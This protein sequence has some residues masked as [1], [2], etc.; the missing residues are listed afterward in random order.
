MSG[1]SVG[2]IVI[3]RNEGERLRICLRSA[4]D[5]A[6]R[7]Y[8]DSGSTDGSQ[9][10]ATTLGFHVVSLDPNVGFT[11]ARARNAGLTFLS[12]RFRDLQFVQT[13][14]G[15][16]EIDPHWLRSA[17]RDLQE[18]P[19]IAVV[20]GRRRERDPDRNIYHKACDIEWRAPVGE[21]SSCGGDALFRTAALLEV[22]GFNP[23]LI[24]GEEPDLCLRLR[25]RGWRVISNGR[26]MTLHDVSIASF[27]QWWR[28]ALRAGYG[29]SELV[30]IHGS[31]SDPSWKRFLISTA[32]WTSLALSSLFVLAIAPWPLSLA[33]PAFVAVL[34]ALQICRTGFRFRDRFSRTTD[35]LKWSLLIFASKFAQVYG[36]GR[37]LL[38]SAFRNRGQIIEYK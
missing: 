29:I 30:A 16:C 33:Y 34:I 36:A 28:R 4:Q 7:V 9:E 22:N 26:D 21:A 37:Y 8:V 11:A 38:N 23:A 35:A 13:V 27:G 19:N 14:D 10:L 12:E 17:L 25:Q 31:R 1:E 20:F 24:S 18:S 15:D 6:Q 3:G 5:F 32:L 2:V